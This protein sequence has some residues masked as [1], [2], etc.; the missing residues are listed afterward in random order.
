[1]MAR[2]TVL[3]HG[4]HKRPV[5]TRGSRHSRFRFPS[6]KTNTTQLGEGKG[7]EFLAYYNEVASHVVDF[8][9]HPFEIEVVVAGQRRRY[10]PDSIRMLVDGTVE[11][12]EVKRSEKDLAD[13]DYRELLARIGEVA[14]LCGW[15]F[16]VLDLE[17]VLG[18]RDRSYNVAVLFG[19]RSKYLGRATDR[20]VG[21][22]IA[23][24][25]RICWRELRDRLAPGDPLEGDAIVEC[26][27]ARGRFSANLDEKLLPST[28]LTPVRP[29]IGQSMI[30]I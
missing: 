5:I 6:M 8:E 21:R 19:A 12:I 20:D 7:E 22:L 24:N 25:E 10:R 1:M 4:G 18:S 9:C 30:R 17:M 16:R 29:F 13:P 14:R 3:Q 11:L 23:K 27:L 26:L 15:R 28:F 2:I